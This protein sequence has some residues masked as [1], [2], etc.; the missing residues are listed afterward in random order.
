MLRNSRTQPQ[1]VTSGSPSVRAAVTCHQHRAPFDPHQAIGERSIVAAGQA[2]ADEVAG[3]PRYARRHRIGAGL[4]PCDL[5]FG[6]ADRN[7]LGPVSHDVG[8][9]LR[10][11]LH[12]L[13]S[14]AV[15]IFYVIPKTRSRFDRYAV[16]TLSFLFLRW[17]VFL[18]AFG[19]RI[20]FISN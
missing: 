2:A 12:D 6:E 15:K 18:D 20:E 7:R 9:R 19:V 11:K 10:L 17:L 3:N 1:L 14:E 8:P 16:C 4:K 5:G 13:K